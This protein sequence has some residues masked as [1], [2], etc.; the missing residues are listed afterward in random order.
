L[1]EK[2]LALDQ[3]RNRWGAIDE[4]LAKNGAPLL[5]GRC[6]AAATPATMTATSA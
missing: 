6:A 4:R 3:T 2:I 1:Q 5:I